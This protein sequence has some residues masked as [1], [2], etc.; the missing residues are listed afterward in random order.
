M[1]T[2]ASGHTPDGGRN[3][4]RE[5]SPDIADANER[6]TSGTGTDAVRGQTSE[7]ARHGGGPSIEDTKTASEP[8]TSS[9]GSRTGSLLGSQSE[10][11]GMGDGAPTGSSQ[12][13]AGGQGKGVVE[14]D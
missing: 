5:G 7:G 8:V 11:T 9:Q 2:E 10:K 13:L 6:N 1:E 14:P 12:G 4:A 3:D